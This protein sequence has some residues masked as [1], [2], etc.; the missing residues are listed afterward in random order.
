M[1]IYLS[2]KTS[3]ISKACYFKHS[4]ISSLK[5]SVTHGELSGLA[6]SGRPV[7]KATE[8]LYDDFF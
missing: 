6:T 4:S 7:A 3:T 8:E 5:Q 1:V 2:V